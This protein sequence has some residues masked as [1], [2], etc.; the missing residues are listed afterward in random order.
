MINQKIITKLE[1]EGYRF[2]GKNKHSACKICHWTKK[3]LL[4]EDTCYKETFY[5]IKA[6]QCC[7]MTPSLVCC[8]SCIFCWRTMNKETTSQKFNLK[9][10]SPK[11][12]INSCIENQRKLLSG[13]GGNEKINLKKFQEAQNPKYWAISL[14]G[15]PTFYPYISSL[16]EELK[17]RDC[18]TFLVT[19]GLMPE[20]LSKMELPTQLY[21]SLDAPTELLYKKIDRSLFKDSWKRLNKTLKLFSKIKTRTVIRLTLMKDINMNNLE[22][23]SKLIK[24]AN[25]DFV[26]CKAYMF[27]GS[28]RQRLKEENMP[29]HKDILEF[30]KQLSELTNIKLVDDK[31]ESRVVLLSNLNKKERKLKF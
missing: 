22:N 7:Q 6:H 25:P 31:E 14:S 18:C 20:V 1:K 4:D 8:N 26:E 30:S 10:D 24:I 2:S 9:P 5:N 11:E 3:S 12:I 27:V 21:L 28:S 13:F 23:Y 17:S 16:V 19:N 29:L 15:E